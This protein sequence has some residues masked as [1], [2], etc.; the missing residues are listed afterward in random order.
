MVK[1][2][3]GDVLQFQFQLNNHTVTQAAGNMAPCAP[4]QD[5]V[6]TAMHSGFIPGPSAN[7]TTVGTFSV[8]V[9]DMEPKYLYCAT[10]PHCNLGMVMIVNP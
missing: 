10:G 3:P 4:L 7:S 8:L 1:A 2:N 9:E 6:P 5:T